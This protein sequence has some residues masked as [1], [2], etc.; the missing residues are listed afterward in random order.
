MGKITRKELS[1]ELN[2]ELDSYS[3]KNELQTL[4]SKVM[5]HL[6]E[7]AFRMTK[8][9]EQGVAF[10]TSLEGNH[11]A[12]THTN[13]S[14]DNSDNS[15]YVVYNAQPT[16]S[17]TQSKVHAR[18][19]PLNGDFS[20]VIVIADK[21]SEGIGCKCQSSGICENGDYIAII[22]HVN[23]STGDIIGTFVYRSTDK[24]LTWDNGTEI[25]INGSP[26]IAYSGDVSGF[27]KLSNG[28]I[29]LW[30]WYPSKESFALF[31][32][33]NGLT[34]TLATIK[35]SPVYNVTEPTFI[36]LDNGVI[37]GYARDNVTDGE[38][39]INTPK[40]AY[41]LKSIDGGTTWET[42]VKSNSIKDMSNNNCAFVKHGNLIEIIYGSRFLHK[43]GYGSIYQSI[44]TQE[45]ILNDVWR[46]SVRIARVNGIPANLSGN[47]DSGYFGS[48]TAEDG[49]S[50]V[51]Y[52]N[53]TKTNSKIYYLKG[54]YNAE[55]YNEEEISKF[56][57]IENEIYGQL[58][59]GD[60]KGTKGQ[61]LVRRL[62]NNDKLF[63]DLTVTSLGDG[64]LSLG[65]TENGTD[66]IIT[67]LSL[68]RNG[69]IEIA[70]GV[71]L[72]ATDKEVDLGTPVRRFGAAYFTGVVG[73]MA[74]PTTDR[75]TSGLIPGVMMFDRT[76]NKPIWRNANNNGWVDA[77]GNEV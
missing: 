22:A 9:K 66:T 4:D 38:D 69:N 67:K 36:E 30:G 8:F 7:K 19:R 48:A 49:T 72:P 5:S 37:I 46:E 2:N 31:S 55:V 23:S 6:A 52:Y 57:G 42:P 58:I 32:D 53:G 14:Y 71:L 60:Y 25:L 54:N 10:D 34:W 1:D 43:D 39:H 44:T 77:N 40:S 26:L 75:P 35:Q 13:V 47:G 68:M 17:I 12:W 21:L 63:I 45:D 16:H 65:K 11:V 74:V 29:I 51:F 27:L 76:L 70:N 41:F 15:F 50:M 24:G 3:T 20:N 62:I 18:K 73:S 28:R 56:K 59:L 64:W 61:L 33:D